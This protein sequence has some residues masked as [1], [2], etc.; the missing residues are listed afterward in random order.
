MEPGSRRSARVAA[1]PVAAEVASLTEI[2]TRVR[3]GLDGP[4]PFS[5]EVTRASVQELG[6]RPGVRV[7]ATWKAAATRVVRALAVARDPGRHVEVVERVATTTARGSLALR[8][9]RLGRGDDALALAELGGARAEA[10]R[11]CA[12]GALRRGGASAT[13]PTRRSACIRLCAAWTSRSIRSAWSEST[14]PSRRMPLCER[15]RLLEHLGGGLLRGRHAPLDR[16]L[17]LLADL[18][19]LLL[20]FLELGPAPPCAPT[21]ARGA[22]RGGPRRRPP[23]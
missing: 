17:G 23:P 8:A 6:L 18:R 16:A 11:R 21:R 12:T 9:G 19:R 10:P 13:C 2:G 15:V 20:G 22:P 4:Q 14:S 7:T 3:L 5:A 1:E